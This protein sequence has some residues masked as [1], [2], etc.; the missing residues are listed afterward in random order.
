M[1]ENVPYIL[2]GQKPDNLELGLIFSCTAKFNILCFNLYR[3]IC[4]YSD[5]NTTF[6][7]F[8]EFK[9]GIIKADGLCSL[10]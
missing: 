4:R 8:L 9:F 3:C 5:P 2:I 10:I 1:I 6:T 7:E